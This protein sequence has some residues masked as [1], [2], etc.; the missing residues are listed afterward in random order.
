MLEDRRRYYWIGLGGGA[1]LMLALWLLPKFGLVPAQ[2]AEQRVAE[3]IAILAQEPWDSVHVMTVDIQ[4]PAANPT[5]AIL[6]G[7]RPNGTPVLVHFAADSPYS[8]PT[9]VQRLAD[10]P[11]EDLDAEVLMVPRS[12]VQARFR[13]RFRENATHVGIAI[14]TGSPP[15]MSAEEEMTPM[16]EPASHDG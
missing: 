16:V 12:M 7:V 11:P 4:G 6:R 8:S 5:D 15:P 9:A 14:Y 10:A 3:D 13:D 2:T 1:L